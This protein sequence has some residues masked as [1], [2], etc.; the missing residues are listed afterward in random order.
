MFE[1]KETDVKQSVVTIQWQLYIIYYRLLRKFNFYKEQLY[2]IL[3]CEFRILIKDLVN[4]SG[5]QRVHKFYQNS[6][7]WNFELKVNEKFK[8][9]INIFQIITNNI[10]NKI[11]G[12]KQKIAYAKVSKQWIVSLRCF[13]KL[14]SDTISVCSTKANMSAKSL[15]VKYSSILYSFHFIVLI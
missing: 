15:L 4:S 10:W 1:K 3:S 11:F 12:T 8:Y 13:Y 2:N 7:E 5:S 6:V 14:V 9:W